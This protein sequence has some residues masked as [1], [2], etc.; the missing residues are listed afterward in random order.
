M[1]DIEL[2]P[3]ERAAL[4]ECYSYTMKG[5]VYFFRFASMVKLM[6]KGL[7][8]PFDRHELSK[9]RPWTKLTALGIAEAERIKRSSV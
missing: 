4:L 8:E 2:S 6:A 7:A 1:D 9:K 3:N 5:Q